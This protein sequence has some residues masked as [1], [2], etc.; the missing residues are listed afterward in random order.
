[1]DEAE[2]IGAFRSGRDFDCEGDVVDAGFI[3]RCCRELKDQIDPRGINLRNAVVVGCLDLAGLDV[4]FPVRLD[5]CDFDSAPV[6]EGA[7]LQ[8]VALTS[9]GRLP[10]LLANGVRIRRDLDLSRSR[11]TGGLLTTASTSKRSAIWLCESTIGGRLLCVDTVVRSDGERSIQADRMRVGGTVR[12]LH[13]FAATGEIRLLGAHIEGSLD[14]TGARI[15]CGKGPALDLGD[16]VIGGSLFLIPDSEGRRPVIR[17]RIDMGSTRISGQLLIRNAR[18]RKS[19]TTPV[20]SGYSR[21]RIRGSALS[22]PRLS[23][24]AELTLEGNCRIVGGLD[25]AMSDLGSL[26]I[27]GDCSLRAD[28]R[29]ALDLTHAEFRSALTL[30]QGVRVRGS[31]RL[32]GAHI[33]GDLSLKGVRFRSPEQVE[34]RPDTAKPIQMPSSTSGSDSIHVSMGYAVRA[35]GVT[36]AGS[37][38][39]DEGFT[40]DGAVLLTGA[41]IA[42]SLVCSGGRLR[43]RDENGDALIAD[44]LK[45]GGS[46]LFDAGF[47]SD[48]SVR[49]PGAT[50]V[51]NLVCSGA[52]LT[53]QDHQGV[54]LRAG[55]ITALGVYLDEGFTAAGTIWLESA[56]IGGSAYLAPDIPA[57]GVTSLEAAHAQIAGTL[58]WSPAAQ[59]DGVVSLQGANAGQL[60]DD[61]RDGRDNAYWPAHGLLRLDGFTY[62]RLGG[63]AAAT[64]QQ[65]LG[66]IRSQYQPD[67]NPKTAPFVAQPYEQLAAA[68]RRA[69]QETE[70]RRIAVARRSDLR[71]YGSL[72]PSRRAGNWLLDKTIKYGYQTWR[73]V[74][75]LILLYLLILALA[76]FAQHHGLI[77]A[78]DNVKGLN[79]E[80]TA[81][82]CTSRYPCFYPAG[83]A[84]DTVIPLISV[85]QATYWRPDGH[86]S[87][88]WIWVAGTWIATGFGWALAT[89]LV[90]GYTGLARRQ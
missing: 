39:L 52:T 16:A 17:G 83:Y 31:L 12:F 30:E 37:A 21:S 26:S 60:A 46:V 28:G 10:G 55:G 11:V 33:R 78:A 81:I 89:L 34:L 64:V 14:L 75:G 42:G 2:L 58:D 44:Q 18:L 71:R 38:F 67:G 32:T 87:W 3:R 73:A 1:M 63:P 20:D 47:S 25:L 62:G 9:C 51:R 90:A 53:G 19:R 57:G 43:G 15:T 59:V 24:G 41:D 36:V 23:V 5:G 45:A 4:P 22:A 72:S 61:W 50:I 82:S 74:A 88:G 13:K 70:A 79:P 35:D 68:Y 84:I 54:A 29:T 40:A 69:G 66:W 49:I 56:T 76:I 27:A 65:R 80:P 48:G 6:L 77:E 7:Q 8:E 85:H 86:A